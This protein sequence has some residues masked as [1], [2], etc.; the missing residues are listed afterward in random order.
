MTVIEITPMGA[1]RPRVTRN[2]TY[3]PTRYTNYKRAI[4]LQ[5]RHIK[6]HDGPVKLTLAFQFRYPKSWSKK[7]KAE[8]HYHASKPD[9]DNLIKG[10]K[11]A[12][13]GIAYRDDAQVVHVEAI[14]YYGERDLIIIEIEEAKRG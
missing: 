10:I 8:T 5:C 4:A 6:K 2:G 11:D 9:T 12:L 14:K 13:N 1:P 7:R 3:N